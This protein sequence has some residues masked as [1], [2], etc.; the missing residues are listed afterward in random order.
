MK[1]V[2][3]FVLAVALCLVFA[4]CG[5]GKTEQGGVS[6]TVSEEAVTPTVYGINGPTAVGLVNMMSD[7]AERYNFR[8][9]G[10]PDEIT[11]KITTGEVDIAA[12]PTNLA[13]TLYAKTG[14]KIKMLACNTLG[15]LSI[16]E[17]GDSVKSVAD[18]KSKTVLS[19]GK[20]ANPEYILKY[21]L[22]KNGIDPDKDLTLK[23]VDDNDALTAE[24][25]TSGAGTLAM[26]PQP[27][28]TAVLSQAAA[29][30]IPLKKVLDINEEWSKVAD[31]GNLVMGCMVVRAEFAKEHPA[32]VEQFLS[33]YEASV[34][35]VE[36]DPEGTAKLCAENKILPSEELALKALPECNVVFIAGA[37]MKPA[38]E[39]YF[40]VLFDANPASVGGAMP[41]EAFYY[42]AK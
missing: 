1:R 28:A 16:I 5:G 14:G 15:V 42:T 9:V 23:F 10:S 41:D 39:P 25:L 22:Q 12:I 18:L 6:S 7:A 3:A 8:V 38:I 26:V 34:K 30:Q 19:S 13:A 36:S 2:M 37:D 40:K 4:G 33:D 27:A 32:A 35:K 31:G 20:G 29:K 11:G 21:I 24:L 17:N